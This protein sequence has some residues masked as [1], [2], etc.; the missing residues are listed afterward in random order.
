MSDRTRWWCDDVSCHDDNYHSE[1]L[2]PIQID[3]GGRR[4]KCSNEVNERHN[5]SIK[6]RHSTLTRAL[7]THTHPS[8]IRFDSAKWKSWI[9]RAQTEAFRISFLSPG[10]SATECIANNERMRWW[11]I[12]FALWLQSNHHHH[13]RGHDYHRHSYTDDMHRAFPSNPLRSFIKNASYL[14]SLQRLQHR[15]RRDFD[16]SSKIHFQW[17][18]RAMCERC[19]VLVQHF[20]ICS[21][22][23]ECRI[24]Y[25]MKYF[26]E[27]NC[28]KLV[29]LSIKCFHFWQRLSDAVYVWRPC[30][31]VGVS[32]LA[33]TGNGQSRLTENYFFLSGTG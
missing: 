3:N 2:L 23:C 18:T 20:T 10:S 14:A 11:K 19:I 17:T 16:I 12:D 15:L 30:A 32:S 24:F 4:W 31:K 27:K 6:F 8:M 21:V 25:R 26:S 9:N 13:H 7:I 1:P 5:F 29:P 28:S 22:E 33:A